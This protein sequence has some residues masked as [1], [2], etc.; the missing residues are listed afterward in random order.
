[1]VIIRVV[2][3]GRERAGGYL[4]FSYLAFSKPLVLW[5]TDNQNGIARG[6]FPGQQDG[7]LKKKK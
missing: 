3:G 1:M 2:G 6:M 4:S 5:C 7:L